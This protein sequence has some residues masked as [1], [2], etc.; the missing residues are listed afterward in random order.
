MD[1]FHHVT[2]HGNSLTVNEMYFRIDEIHF[3]DVV[4]QNYPLIRQLLLVSTSF[5]TLI[6]LPLLTVPA[7]GIPILMIGAIEAAIAFSIKRRYALRIGKQLGTS[8]VVISTDRDELE[9]LRQHIRN[10][11]ET[12]TEQQ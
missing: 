6:G 12:R 5:C 1:S 8:K 4:Q 7:L 11:I 2:V 9:R 10:A 3:V